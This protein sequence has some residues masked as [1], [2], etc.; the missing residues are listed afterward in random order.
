VA[1]DRDHAAPCGVNAEAIM[2]PRNILAT[3]TPAELA[4]AVSG[5]SDS[6][7]QTLRRAR[8]SSVTA[9]FASHVKRAKRP[10]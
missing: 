6:R 4:S 8:D 2:P 1:L 7:S 10:V 5:E 3:A 9:D